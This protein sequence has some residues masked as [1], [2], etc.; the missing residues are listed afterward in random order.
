MVQGFWSTEFLASTL[1]INNKSH[2]ASYMTSFTI[3]N[4]SGGCSYGCKLWLQKMSLEANPVL[5]HWPF[6]KGKFICLIGMMI[7]K[8]TSWCWGGGGAGRDRLFHVL[9]T[10]HSKK[11]FYGHVLGFPHLLGSQVGL[12]TK[13]HSAEK[14]RPTPTRRNSQK[15]IGK[16]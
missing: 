3:T 7:V 1:L 15:G 12:L 6:G 14:W 2:D 4:F 10:G 8:C 9:H 13:N 5:S 11:L 16:K